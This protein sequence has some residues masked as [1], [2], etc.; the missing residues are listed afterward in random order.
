METR[1]WLSV[2]VDD[3][4]LVLLCYPGEPTEFTRPINTAVWSDR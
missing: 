2:R 3:S 1:G 4:Q